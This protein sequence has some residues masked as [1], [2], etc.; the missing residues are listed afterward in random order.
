MVYYLSY[1]LLICLLWVFPLKCLLSVTQ[2]I[3]LLVWSTPYTLLVIIKYEDLSSSSSD[4]VLVHN[5]NLSLIAL[6]LFVWN[7]TSHWREQLHHIPSFLENYQNLESSNMTWRLKLDSKSSRKKFMFELSCK[8]QLK[9]NHS[10]EINEKCE[11]QIVY[12]L[13][14]FPLQS[15]SWIHINLNLYFNPPKKNKKKLQ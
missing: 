8:N 15:S 1:Q 5:K 7:H 13:L 11:T 12:F 4:Q 3:N 2:Q 10:I 9:T 6:L 14:L